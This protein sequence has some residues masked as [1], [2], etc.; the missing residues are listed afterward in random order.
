MA[1]GSIDTSIDPVALHQAA[2]WF[3]AKLVDPT[4]DPGPPRPGVEVDLPEVA[5]CFEEPTRQLGEVLAELRDNETAVVF[6]R[7]QRDEAA[8]RLKDY[9]DR[10]GRYYEALCEL[11]GNRKLAARMRRIRRG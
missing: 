3:A 6:A 9:A 2:L 1:G 10:A 11:I 4:F 7:A 8:E 5:W